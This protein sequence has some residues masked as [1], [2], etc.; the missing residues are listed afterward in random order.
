[1]D[2]GRVFR[3]CLDLNFFVRA[4]TTP[5]RV[6]PA[7]IPFAPRTPCFVTLAGVHHTCSNVAK[8]DQKSRDHQQL[9]HEFS[10]FKVSLPSEQ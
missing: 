7:K 10:P 4:M 8:R 5:K 3:L 2:F 9:L 6:G 1:M